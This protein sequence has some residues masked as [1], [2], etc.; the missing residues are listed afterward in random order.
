M[1]MIDGGSLEGRRYLDDPCSSANKIIILIWY[2]APMNFAPHP[3][4]LFRLKK[5]N[6]FNVKFQE[7]NEHYLFHGT[8]KDTLP[9]IY[10]QGLDFRLTANGMLGKGVYCAESSTKSDQYAGTYSLANK[11]L[12][13]IFLLK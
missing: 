12:S 2:S 8:K 6:L 11:I 10:S 13:W 4:A 1:M 3:R 9:K 5:K 7:I